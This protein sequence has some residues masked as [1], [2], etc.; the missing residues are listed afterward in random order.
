MAGTDCWYRFPGSGNHEELQ[1]LLSTCSASIS[2]WLLL[3]GPKWLLEHLP[4]T[5]QMVVVWSLMVA[6]D[7]IGV[8]GVKSRRLGDRFTVKMRTREV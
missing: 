6:V 7:S 3:H 8:W 2:S 1:F 4:L 5:P